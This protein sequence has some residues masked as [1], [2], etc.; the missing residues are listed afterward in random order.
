MT[1]GDFK[2]PLST[3]AITRFKKNTNDI[4]DLSNNIKHLDIIN[5]CLSYT[6]Q[7]QNKHSFQ[8]YMAHSPIYTRP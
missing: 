5:I 1:V 2:T 7:L 8:V 4:E 3:L 6:Q